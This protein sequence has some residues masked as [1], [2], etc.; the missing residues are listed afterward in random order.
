MSFVI[1]DTEK[2][3]HDG[4]CVSVCPTNIL[5]MNRET[6]LPES[7]RNAEMRCIRCGHCVAVCPEGAVTVNGVRPEDC[8]PIDGKQQV[9]IDGIEQLIKSRRSIRSYKNDRIDAGLL[10]RLIDIAR[11]APSGGNSQQVQWLVV[12]SP[13]EVRNYSSMAMEFY[14]GLLVSKHP[15]GDMYDVATMVKKWES[16]GDPILNGAPAFILAHA[17]KEYPVAS[18]DS[19]IALSY[20]DIAANTMGLACCWAGFFMIA[21]SQ[22]PSVLKAINLPDGHFC[23]GALMIGY[24]KNTYHRLPPRKEAKV[25]WRE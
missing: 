22:S 13:E 16:G 10:S 21:A 5:F 12:N 14:K 8:V 25:L 4:I 17:P 23:A 24:P 9:P 15:I 2:C 7:V 3:L 6:K 19:S 20:I 11:Y 18:V 1:V